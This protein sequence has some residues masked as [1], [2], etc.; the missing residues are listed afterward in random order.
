MPDLPAATEYC[1]RF[2]EA[3]EADGLLRR[4]CVEVPWRREHVLLFGRRRAVPRLVAWCGEPGVNYRYAG[5]DHRCDGW[6]PLLAELRE[7][8][9]VE[10][11]FDSNLVLLNRYRDGTDTMGWHRDDEPGLQARVASLSIGSPRRFLLRAPGAPRSVALTLAHGSLLL[12]D[13]RLRH[14]LPRTRRQVG[15]RVNLTFRRVAAGAP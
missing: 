2:L 13:G 1:A 14:A 9:R 5:T 3:P 11:G 8:L 6:F 4:L 15:E 7:R 10:A 12:F